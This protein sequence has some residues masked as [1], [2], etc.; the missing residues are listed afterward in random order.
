MSPAEYS[1]RK[2]LE[3]LRNALV[4]PEMDKRLL[5]DN[6]IPRKFLADRN[7][8]LIRHDFDIHD[9]AAGN[10]ASDPPI[11]FIPRSEDV[12]S[13]FPLDPDAYD[14]ETPDAKADLKFSDYAPPPDIKNTHHTRW[15]PTTRGRWLATYLIKWALSGFP[16]ALPADVL[17]LSEECGICPVMVPH[18]FNRK[19]F[20]ISRH[21][22]NIYNCWESY[23]FE[24]MAT[25]GPP[26]YET[27]YPHLIMVT[28]N[29][30]TGHDGWITHG[31]LTSIVTAMRNRAVQPA[32]EFFDPQEQ[33]DCFEGQL[34]EHRSR[35]DP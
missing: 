32:P 33:M 25:T 30:C 15:S 24:Y 21:G 20:G 31:E 11:L 13:K 2:K 22:P 1:P 18:P 29:S 26:N 8:I 9:T 4:D 28:F 16:R 14:P 23:I 5:D 19:D 10:L 3:S 7:I 27:L 35:I 12:L 6:S 34:N 17:T